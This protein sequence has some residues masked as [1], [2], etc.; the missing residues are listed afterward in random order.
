MRIPGAKG[1][2]AGEGSSRW[3]G[4]AA[5]CCLARCETSTAQSWHDL[6]PGKQSGSRLSR[7]REAGAGSFSSQSRRG[8]PT[9]PRG[10]AGAQAGPYSVTSVWL[11]GD[12][13]AERAVELRASHARAIT[14]A[15]LR[16]AEGP[17]MSSASNRRQ[18]GLPSAAAAGGRVANRGRCSPN[19][20]RLEILP[21]LGGD[22]HPVRV[23][24][25][26]QVAAQLVR[27]QIAVVAKRLELAGPV[28]DDQAGAGADRKGLGQSVAFF[29]VGV[30]V[31]AHVMRRQN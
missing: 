13:E 14:T 19:R 6:K 8:T 16:L 10:R 29:V 23:S 9:D 5:R 27:L 7:G 11:T 3:S 26:I 20:T 12:S 4:L 17:R 31:T 22:G 18:V 25:A 2:A 24:I 15:G 1:P 21:R 30:Q 28:A